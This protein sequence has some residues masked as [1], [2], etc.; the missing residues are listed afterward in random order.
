M[1][2]RG[3]G[4]VGSRRQDGS[5]VVSEEEL[6]LE[7]ATKE[8]GRVRARKVVD[9][10][11]VE[12]VVPRGVEHAVVEHQPPG[13]ADSGEVETLPD[14]SVSIPVFE[15]RLVVEK[16]LVVR[17]RIVIRKQTVF[18]EHRFEA[19]LRRERV[20]VEADPQLGPRVEDDRAPSGAAAR[21]RSTRTAAPSGEP[22][23]SPRRRARRPR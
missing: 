19:D 10:E 5:L 1:S 22:P 7:I 8:S 23:A 4:P 20:E 16:R 11:R 3:A 2:R 14:G 18:E 13:E 9:E 21:R 6:E 12:Q 17:E 15:E